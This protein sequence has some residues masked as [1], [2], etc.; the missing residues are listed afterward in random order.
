MHLKAFSLEP[1]RYPTGEHYPFNLALLQRTRPVPLTAPITFFA[2]EN[3]TGKS[4]LLE[5][6]ARRCAIHIWENATNVRVQANP[7]EHELYRYLS[8]HWTDGPVP[9]AFFSGEMFRDFSRY[10]EEWSLQDAGILEFFGGRSLLSQSHGQSMMSYFRSRYRIRGLYL[11]DEPETALSPTSQLDLLRILMEA[12][13]GGRAQFIIVSHS[14]ILLG[15]PGASI[16]S[17]DHGTLTPI[18]YEGTSHYKIYRD[19]MTAREDVIATTRPN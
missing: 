18:S 9:G 12:G 1:E 14:P 5:A 4:T 2:G 6:L 16:Y 17:F 15:C 11:I 8:V 13:Q 19:Y 3:G 7:Y 10:L